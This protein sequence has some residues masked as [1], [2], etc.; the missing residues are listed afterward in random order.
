MYNIP[1]RKHEFYHKKS[2]NERFVNF[3]INLQWENVNIKTFINHAFFWIYFMKRENTLTNNLPT[4]KCSYKWH[5]A[6]YCFYFKSNQLKQH[7][8]KQAHWLNFSKAPSLV[9]RYFA[10]RLVSQIA[11]IYCTSFITTF[12]MIQNYNHVHCGDE[13]STPKKIISSTLDP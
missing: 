7:A 4:E 9:C 8:Q 3:F 10:L 2:L 5:C 12:V 11:P 6:S 1:L 13:L